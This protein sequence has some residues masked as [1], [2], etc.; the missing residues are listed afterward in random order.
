MS[1][2][3]EQNRKIRRAMTVIERI[4]HWRGQEPAGKQAAW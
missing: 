1:A 3:R 2:Q 4:R